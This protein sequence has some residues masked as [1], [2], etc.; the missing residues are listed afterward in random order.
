MM[1]GMESGRTLISEEWAGTRQGNGICTPGRKNSMCQDT[2]LLLKDQE[3]YSVL[4]VV[5][6]MTGEVDRCQIRTGSKGR[7][8][9]F[10]FQ[11]QCNGMVLWRW[12]KEMTN[13]LRRNWVGWGL[14]PGKKWVSNYLRGF[15]SSLGQGWQLLG[16][17]W[18]QWGKRVG[19]IHS[20]NSSALFLKP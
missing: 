9:D 12:L 14:G 16:P 17:R 15:A 18:W 6:D 1:W 7:G 11:F 10:R 19:D 8:D 20:E 5:W 13:I 3:G 4:R 2:S